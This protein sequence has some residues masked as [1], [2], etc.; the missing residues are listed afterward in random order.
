MNYEQEINLSQ[1]AIE[2][3]GW[4]ENNLMLVQGSPVRIGNPDMMIYSDVV[5]NQGWGAV[6]EG[7]QSTGGQWTREEKEIYH[8]NELEL[9][10]AKLAVKTFVKNQKFKLVHLYLDNMAARYYLVNKWGTKNEIMTKTSKRIWEYCQERGI[11]ITA[12]W[13]PSR[14]NKIADWRSRQRPNASE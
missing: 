14:E 7:G 1:E 12:S 6:V 3:L 5:S 9:L 2:E 11:E 10:A 13:I 4:W 8:I